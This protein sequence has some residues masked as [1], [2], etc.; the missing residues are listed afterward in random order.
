[1]VVDCF[2]FFNELELLELRCEELKGVVDRHFLVESP[3]TFSGKPKPLY[4]EENAL[5]FKKY[6]ITQVVVELPHKGEL[7]NYQP[8]T[9]DHASR[10][11]G[12]NQVVSLLDDNDQVLIS[13]VDE[14]PRSS[15]ILKSPDTVV[16]MQRTFTYWLNYQSPEIWRGTIQMPA[17]KLRRLGGM[18]AYSYRWTWAHQNET[19]PVHLGDAGWHFSYQG[20]IKRIQEKLV[21]AAHVEYSGE[22]FTDPVRMAE[23]FKTGEDLFDRPKEGFHLVPIDDTYPRYLREHPERFAHMICS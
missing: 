18:A 22:Y 12:F 3:T 13:D 10:M 23:K 16:Y 21:A 7:I 14:I 9:N 20:G 6:P 15:L 17:E 4:Y 19:A 8:W 5:L 2:T 1:M 11:L